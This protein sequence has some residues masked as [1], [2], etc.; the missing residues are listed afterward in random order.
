MQGA[1]HHRFRRA[2][3]PVTRIS[4][5]V[6]RHIPGWRT[7]QPGERSRC[8]ELL[9]WLILPLLLLVAVPHELGHLVAARL[10]GIR[11]LE[12]GIGLPPRAASFTRGGIRWTICWLLPLGAFVRLK[13]EDEGSEPDDFAARPAWQ[14]ILVAGAGPAVNVVVGLVAIA[15]GT[16]AVGRPT[17]LH[18]QVT[19]IQPG[20]PAAAA[21]VRVGD[22]LVRGGADVVP[23]FRALDSRAP[24]ASTLVVERA[25]A[26]LAVPLPAG[27]LSAVGATVARRMGYAPVQGLDGAL[28]TLVGLPAAFASRPAGPAMPAESL[29]IG[30]VGVAQLMGEL[31]DAGIPPAA[32]FAALLASLSLGL[33]I[34]NLLPIPPL[35]GSRVLFGGLDAAARRRV[36]GRRLG[37]RLN[38]AGLVVLVAIFLAVTGADVVRTLSGRAI[39]PG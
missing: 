25:G 4:V 28:A 38:L 5:I 27:D 36:V 9:A 17:G 18:A 34:A 11:V 35:D 24:A 20:S 13:G 14:R 22:V 19:A 30:W 15:A 32:W 12:F 33:G 3:W 8:L 10:L 16:L 7:A 31:A 37:A 39:L 23:G 21:G 1:Y 26:T 6:A 2:F 29:V